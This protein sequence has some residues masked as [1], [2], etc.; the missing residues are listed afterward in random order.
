MSAASRF[1]ESGEKKSKPRS[2]SQEKRRSFA[3]SRSTTKSRH[4]DV[5]KKKKPGS[6]DKNKNKNNLVSAESNDVKPD[7][8]DERKP[9]MLPWWCIFIPWF[10]LLSLTVTCAVFT[11]LYTFSFGAD[12][13]LAW[14]RSFLFT[15]LGEGLITE[16]LLVLF[17]A[18]FFTFVILLL[19][20]NERNFEMMKFLCNSFLLL[21]FGKFLS[22]YSNI[23]LGFCDLFFCLFY[24]C[25]GFLNISLNEL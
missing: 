5:D 13:S 6:D 23:K 14:L 21:L 8:A 11:V 3:S 25:S 10:L 24:A 16:P 1:S 9:G 20:L 17:V 12:K 15:L 19:D 2:S 4:S 22:T 18:L 7:V